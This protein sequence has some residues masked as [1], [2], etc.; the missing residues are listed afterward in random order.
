MEPL[1]S[2]SYKGCLVSLWL[3]TAGIESRGL[4]EVVSV[5]HLGSYPSPFHARYTVLF[6]GKSLCTA[7]TQGEGCYVPEQST[8]INY[9]EFSP[10]GILS[11][12]FHRCIYSVWYILYGLMDIHFGKSLCGLLRPFAIPPSWRV[13]PFSLLPGVTSKLVQI[14][15]IYFLP[16]SQ[17]QPFLQGVLALWLEMGF[18]PRIWYS[19]STLLLGHCCSL[20]PS[21]ESNEICV[22]K[23][24]H[25]CA[26]FY[27]YFYMQPSVARQS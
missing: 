7:Y 2:R 17:N 23:L 19:L 18:E 1:L 3:P 4:A 8:Y 22:C 16:Q 13:F 14:Q 10:T 9:L 15:L 11:I 20:L 21:W 26:H 25:V 24:T 12:S 5:R 6:G 27:K